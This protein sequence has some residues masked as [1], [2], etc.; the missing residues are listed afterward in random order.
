MLAMATS[1]LGLDFEAKPT[2]A[3]I[4]HIASLADRGGSFRYVVTPNVD[5]MVRLSA[6]PD[7]RVLYEC[8]A[9]ILN[10]GRILEVLAGRDYLALPASPGADPARL[11][12]RY[13]IDGPKILK[14]WQDWRRTKP[15]D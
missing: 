10:D 8:A 13:A 4:S 3:A 7:L 1:F 12:K 9:L 5:Y 11:A 14:I 6:R 15:D 2:Q